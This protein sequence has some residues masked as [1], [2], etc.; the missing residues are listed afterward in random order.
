MTMG[1]AKLF[2]HPSEMG[3]EVGPFREVY[4]V[5]HRTVTAPDAQINTKV[6]IELAVSV[7]ITCCA[8]IR[9]EFGTESPPLEFLASLVANELMLAA[10]ASAEQ[11]DTMIRAE[12]TKQ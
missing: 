4:E 11:V 2:I 3:D 6:L 12:R 7:A 10:K 9:R 1:T 8:N 5:L